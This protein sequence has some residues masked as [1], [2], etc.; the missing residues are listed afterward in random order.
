MSQLADEEG[1]WIWAIGSDLE[2]VKT[3][4]EHPEKLYEWKLV[5]Q[6][7]HSRNKYMEFCLKN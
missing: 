2:Q 4:C 1:K 7:F 6:N 3:D 5:C